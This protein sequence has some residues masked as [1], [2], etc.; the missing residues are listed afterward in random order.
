MRLKTLL[1]VAL[2]FAAS[3]AS[4]QSG[5]GGCL[6]GTYSYFDQ[7]GQL[8]GSATVGC[9]PNSSWG[10]VTDDAVFSPGCYA[11]S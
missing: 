11:A 5:G 8:V 3:S 10:V 1:I 7:D 9:N 2:A 6:A 4:A